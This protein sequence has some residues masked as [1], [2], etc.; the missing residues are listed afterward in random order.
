MSTTENHC[1]AT[2]GRS[3]RQRWG[4][5]WLA[6]L[7][8]HGGRDSNALNNASLSSSLVL[9][10]HHQDAGEGPACV[11]EW[12]GQTEDLLDFHNCSQLNGS[13]SRYQVNAK[14][15]Q[16]RI[17]LERALYILHHL[18]KFCVNVWRQISL[19][20]VMVRGYRVKPYL[21]LYSLRYHH[22][23]WALFKES[24]HDGTSHFIL[25]SEWMSLTKW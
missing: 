19:Q 13:T 16:F 7:C 14:S 5:T 1:L 2:Q 8:P 17:R 20:N 24:L 4:V 12:T 18:A 10:G 11:S 23:R 6:W 25:C 21:S 15:S 9:L 3:W 22:F